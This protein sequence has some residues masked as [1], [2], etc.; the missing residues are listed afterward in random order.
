MKSRISWS[1]LGPCRKSQRENQLGSV[2]AKNATTRKQNH[3][4][5]ARAEARS[6]AGYQT[7]LSGEA[8]ATPLQIH[9][10]IHVGSRCLWQDNGAVSGCGTVE[11]GDLNS[12]LLAMQGCRV[13]VAAAG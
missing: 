5:E 12:R 6:S 13:G 7:R 1:I 4:N 11:C 10:W 2:Q 3:P 9:D 8:L